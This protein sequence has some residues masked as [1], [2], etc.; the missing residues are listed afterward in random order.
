MDSALIRQGLFEILTAREF[1]SL[2]IDVSRFDDTTSLLNDVGLDSMQ[3]LELVVAI[4]NTFGIRINTKRLK[5]E[6]FDRFDRL[7]DFVAESI[8][9][10]G[11]ARND[12]Q[13][14]A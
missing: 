13:E 12:V 4:E 1:T 7:I 10:D 6:I 9:V 2:Q 5:V 11:G 8:R 3:L 14:G